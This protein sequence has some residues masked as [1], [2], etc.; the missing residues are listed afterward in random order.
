MLRSE[1]FDITLRITQ[2]DQFFLMLRGDL[3]IYLHDFL[4]SY[5]ALPAAAVDLVKV[6]SLFQEA[7]FHVFPPNL[8]SAQKFVEA[9]TVDKRKATGK[10]RGWDVIEIGVNLNYPLNIIISNSI[11]QKYK[12]LFYQL[13]LLNVRVSLAPQL[14][15]VSRS[16]DTTWSILNQ[17]KEKS[18]Q[19]ILLD[20]RILHNNFKYFFNTILFFLSTDVIIPAATKFESELPNYSTIDAF[21]EN[22]EDFVGGI[23]EKC[24]LVSDS[25]QRALR[26]VCNVSI[27]FVDLVNAHLCQ[28]CAAAPKSVTRRVD[29]SQRSELSLDSSLSDEREDR[30]ISQITAEMKARRRERIA[31]V[32][33]VSESEAWSA[34][35]DS[36]R[37]RFESSRSEFLNLLES[38]PGFLQS[39]FL[40]LHR[41]LRQAYRS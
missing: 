41:K 4:N 17:L 36:L 16:L 31:K 1:E 28:K 26:T 35:I 29:S 5:L 18:V 7:V 2:L 38:Q 25:L 34:G 37:K 10:E 22:F 3:C 19:S 21:V 40:G 11:L 27:D 12:K 39:S 20:A 13:L 15:R 8:A 6:Q 32:R 14:Q 24:F 9:L 33:E 30:S 23:F